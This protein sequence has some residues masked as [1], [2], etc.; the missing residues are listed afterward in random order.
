MQCTKCDRGELVR[1]HRK[2]FFEK[3]VFAALSYFPWKCPVCKHRLL[4]KRRSNGPKGLHA[5]EFGEDAGVTQGSPPN[6]EG[7]DLGSTLTS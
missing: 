4:L 5:R 1:S 7:L 6:G 3:R 2:G